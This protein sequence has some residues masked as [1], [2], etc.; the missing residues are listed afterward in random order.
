M[1]TFN[2][3]RTRSQL[4]LPALDPSALGRSPL[5][6]AR[7]ALRHGFNSQSKLRDHTTMQEGE[8]TDDDEED[9]ILLSPRNAN[10]YTDTNRNKKRLSDE[11]EPHDENGDPR[12]LKRAKTDPLLVNSPLFTEDTQSH[13]S[14]HSEEP[15]ITRSAGDPSVPHV[16]L[17]TIP[18]AGSPWRALSPMKV[19]VLDKPTKDAG[20]MEVDVDTPNPTPPPVAPSTPR[21]ANSTPTSLPHTPPPNPIQTPQG[22]NLGRLPING[23]G[24]MSPLTPLPSTP[25]PNLFAGGAL[26]A[27]TL[28]V[29][30]NFCLTCFLVPR[31]V[32]FSH[33]VL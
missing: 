2:S 16:D 25:S 10:V 9:E 28:G 22:L 31:R 27:F 14:P 7:L 3:K 30:H 18:V 24:P 4:T 1:S 23:S 15:Q 19:K 8:V 21:P 17:R 12:E 5:K 32:F 29:S 33:C 6:D 13:T 11:H 26:R 20:A